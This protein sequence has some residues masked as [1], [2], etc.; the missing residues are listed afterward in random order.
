[1]LKEAA[2]FKVEVKG[3]KVVSADMRI[4]YNHRGIE[5]LATKKTYH[6]NIFLCERVCGICSHCHSTC[7]CQTIEDLAGIEAPARARYIRTIVAELERLHSH[8]LW[9]GVAMHVIGFDTAFMHIWKE[10]ENIMEAIETITG[11]RVNYA[12][13]TIGGVRRDITPE[14]IPYL[15]AQLI[16]IRTAATKIEK[17]V[18]E[19]RLVK[20]RTKEVGVLDKNTAKKMCVVGPTVRASGVEQD[21]RKDDPY[22]AYN[23]LDWNIVT[24]SEGDVLARV[25]VRLG[26]IF[27]SINITEQAL[28]N[29][30]EGEI[31]LEEVQEFPEREV[32]DR[33]EAHR[34]ELVYYIRSNGTNIPERVKIRTPSFMN[35]A[36]LPS[37]LVGESIADVLLI[38][39]S[40][41]P[42]FSC[43]DRSVMV[44]DKEKNRSFI[45]TLEKL[46]RRRF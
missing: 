41:D 34:G 11:K 18:T 6:Q 23:E 25:L 35:N 27:Q 29:L 33:V 26:E 45:T 2:F 44:I 28:R 19:D 12:V 46:A 37:M 7:Y 38:V 13:N 30:P 15:Q 40:I 39:A 8:F 43:T 16:K 36:A 42:C 10:R 1:M 24:Y 14:I 31:A 20:A 5:D 32:F 17:F 21:V 3:E 9:F 22:A 4:G